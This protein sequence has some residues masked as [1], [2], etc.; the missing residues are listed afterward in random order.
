MWHFTW[1][2]FTIHSMPLEID[3]GHG[4]LVHVWNG[5]FLLPKAPNFAPNV[6]NQTQALQKRSVLIQNN[7][8]PIGNVH[9]QGNNGRSRGNNSV[10]YIPLGCNNLIVS[11]SGPAR[12]GGYSNLILSCGPS[13]PTCH[14]IS[15]ILGC[16]LSIGPDNNFCTILL[17]FYLTINCLQHIPHVVVDFGSGSNDFSHP[18]PININAGYVSPFIQT[19]PPSVLP[20]F[21]L[22][23]QN[24]LTKFLLYRMDSQY[25][26]PI[27]VLSFLNY[28]DIMLFI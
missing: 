5:M 16:G 12:R 24:V 9:G 14:G 20:G 22:I 6:Q 27:C 25:E 26:E 17:H 19:L 15:S 28:Y 13:I 21:V 23:L 7:H 10:E 8:Q 11:Q 3:Y 4:S 1:T 2:L 18:L